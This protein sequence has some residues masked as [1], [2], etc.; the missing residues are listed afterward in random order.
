MS[1]VDNSTVQTVVFVQFYPNQ[2][3]VCM[4]IVQFKRKKNTNVHSLQHIPFSPVLLS[5]FLS[6]LLGAI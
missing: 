5:M 3:S 6:A 4:F 2:T 1:I